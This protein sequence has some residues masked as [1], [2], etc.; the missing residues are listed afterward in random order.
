MENWGSEGIW[1]VGE[2]IL[3]YVKGV[4]DGDNKIVAADIT[5]RT[6]KARVR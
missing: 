3:W 1:R 6:T 4:T 2:T 5:V